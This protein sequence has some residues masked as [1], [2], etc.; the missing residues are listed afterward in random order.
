VRC[1]L[2]KDVFTLAGTALNSGNYLV[3]GGWLPPKINIVAPEHNI[4]FREML[5]RLDRIGRTD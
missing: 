1:T 2:E 5:K 3:Y 4:S